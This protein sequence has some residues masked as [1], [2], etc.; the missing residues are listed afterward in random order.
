MTSRAA[1][2]LGLTDRGRIEPGKRAELVLLDP[3]RYVDTASYDDPKR[4]PDGVLGVWS[5]GERVVREG[6]PTGA[7]PGGVVRVPAT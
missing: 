1:N 7:R 6:E 2:R 3:S 5:A 4:S